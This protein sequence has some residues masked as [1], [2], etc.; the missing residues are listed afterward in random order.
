MKPKILVMISVAAEKAGMH[1]QTLRVYESRGLL[2]PIRSGGNTRLYS[3]EDIIKLQRIQHLSQ[4][5]MSLAGIE[6]I[7]VLE[8]ERDALL[9]QNK[10]LTATCNQ[11]GAKE[12][13]LRMQL[14]DALS[15]I[16]QLH[17]RRG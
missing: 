5:G 4:Q 3:E 6:H 11:Q 8:E 2:E 15:Q 12:R 9:E 16:E 10:Y 1:P 17:D 14:A 13:H 7:L